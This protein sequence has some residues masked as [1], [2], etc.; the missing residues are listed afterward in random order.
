MWLEYPDLL[1]KNR[2]T[3]GAYTVTGNGLAFL[4][5]RISYTFGLTGLLSP[6]STAPSLS[7]TYNA[8][9]PAKV[10]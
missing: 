1:L 8:C 5:G 6:H 2:I 3:S 4:A 7:L 10:W 9:A